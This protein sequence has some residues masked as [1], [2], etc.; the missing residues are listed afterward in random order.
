M[1][2]LLGL[3]VL[4]S[5]FALGI[6]VFETV[7]RRRKPHKFCNGQGCRWCDGGRVFRSPLLRMKGK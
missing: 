1:T 3:I 6:V 4:L 2:A 5:A 7:T